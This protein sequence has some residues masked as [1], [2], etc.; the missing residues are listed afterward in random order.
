MKLTDLKKNK[1]QQKNKEVMSEI[2]SEI[3]R[4][5]DAYGFVK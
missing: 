1:E 4:Y 5:D 3:E 2:V